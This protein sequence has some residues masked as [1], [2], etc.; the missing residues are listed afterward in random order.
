MGTEEAADLA[1]E[2]R[3]DIRLH[4]IHFYLRH[5]KYIH[6]SGGLL[7]KRRSWITPLPRKGV[8]MNIYVG[9]LSL[10]V[11][12]EELRREFMAFGEVVSVTIMND[13]YIGSGQSRGYA[14]VKMPS[15]SEGKAAIVA[16]NEK[17]LRHMT[18]NVVEALP[19]SDNKDKGFLHS[20]RLSHFS[21]KVRQRRY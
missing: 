17:A 8:N 7:A 5:T 20:R 18:I 19:L 13:K 4:P 16:L 21:G 3:E 1:E 12:E 6:N 14:F 11:T 15:Q 9:N 2:D 10:E